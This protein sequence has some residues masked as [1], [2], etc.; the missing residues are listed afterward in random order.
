MHVPV[1]VNEVVDFLN[2]V[3]G[4]VFL[5]GTVGLGGH[6]TAILNAS[7][8]NYL[9]GTDKDHESLDIA[10]EKLEAFTGRFT[11][12]HADFKHL[13]TLSI[14][15]DKIDGFLFDLGVSSFQLENPDRGFSYSREAPLDM[16]MD[17][18]GKISAY[19]VI[20]DYSYDELFEVFKKYGEIENPTRIT[21]Q[22]VFHRKQKK[23]E[24]TDEL[25][26]I[27]RRIAP[28]RKTMDPLARVFQAVRI[29]V[30]QELIGLEAFFSK[31]VH[32]IKPGSRIVIISFHSLED[33]IVKSVFKTAKQ[34]QLIKLL[35]K[36]PLAAKKDE[37]KMNIRA[38]SAKLRACEKI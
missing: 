24:S 11:F 7:P 36:K 30:N 35:T 6:S 28:K 14:E 2:A 23:I 34:D 10:K 33:R 1:L 26:R 13:E 19:D 32:S 38:R 5:D 12:F 22:I 4:G 15:I 37:L 17:K 31:L 20:N 21:E 29:E 25:K 16:R 9:Y 3:K 8:Y 18:K 27:I